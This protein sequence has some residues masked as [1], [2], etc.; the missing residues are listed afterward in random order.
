MT[1]TNFL[2]RKAVSVPMV[3]ALAEAM[4]N[5]PRDSS[6][7]MSSLKREPSGG[8]GRVASPTDR[9][10][11]RLGTFSLNTTK[12]LNPSPLQQDRTIAGMLERD[13]AAKANGSVAGDTASTVSTSA[14]SVWD[15]LDDLKHR[16]RK[17][18]L[19]G[20]ISGFGKGSD[21]S[22]GRPRTATTTATT[23]SSSP[24]NNNNVSPSGSFVGSTGNSGSSS[25][26]I[27]PLLHASL[28]RVKQ[29]VSAEVYKSIEATA[30]DTFALADLVGSNA[31]SGATAT[32]STL[33]ITDRQVRRKVD[34]L[35]RSLTEMCLSIAEA[36]LMIAKDSAVSTPVST[37]QT[38]SGSFTGHHPVLGLGRPMTR[39]SAVES[40]RRDFLEERGLRS[41]RD[42]V[43]SDRKLISRSFG[44]PEVRR[45]S[46]Q[47]LDEPVSS[48]SNL[49]Q[50]A[51]FSE[52]V[53]RSVA[54][55]ATASDVPATKL[56][57][58]SQLLKARREASAAAAAA[59][60]NGRPTVEGL[61]TRD[62]DGQIDHIMQDL[63]MQEASYH[64]AP[65]RA[66]GGGGTTADLL[67]SRRRAED[68]ATQE[69]E[70]E[71]EQL[72]QE[73]RRPI[74]HNRNSSSATITQSSLN[75]QRNSPLSHL[76]SGSQ[77]EGAP[78]MSAM[79]RMARRAQLTRSMQEPA[80]SPVEASRRFFD[81]RERTAAERPHRNT[82]HL[83]GYSQRERERESKYSALE[84]KRKSLASA[85]PST[86][87]VVRSSAGGAGGGDYD[88]VQERLGTRD[89]ET[90]RFLRRRVE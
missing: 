20:N 59:A 29:H 21:S 72:T 19:T 57:R 42:S 4:E 18:E 82:I 40:S 61:M 70:R 60:A 73:L 54:A 78:A 62:R 8:I 81:D 3:D 24:K 7:P 63:E 50:S 31:T 48:R 56:A 17:L 71:I 55:A 38:P 84:L 52:I 87:R 1:T 88:D 76:R 5:C 46:M 9:A 51:S 86:S 64:R 58:A 69:R 32:P 90:R 33:G 28:T 10:S 12:T 89:G 30:K 43:L 65:S 34:S 44:S 14:A 47:S 53:R 39:E 15:E 23:L 16:I 26:G 2:N 11:S 80:L 66:T 35:C 13:Q 49:Q 22:G 74:Y 36:R 79:D 75:N 37:T 83:D 45:P 41:G 68:R 77:D 85:T 67:R 25:S 6:R 27:H